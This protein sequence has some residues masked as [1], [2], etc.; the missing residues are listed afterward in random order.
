MVAFDLISTYTKKKKRKEKKRKR[1]ELNL[2][3]IALS[4]AN[5][6]LYSEY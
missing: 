2:T 4:S 1:K 5:F 3:F 6:K